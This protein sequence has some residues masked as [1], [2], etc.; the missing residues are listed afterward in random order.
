MRVC[1]DNNVG[2]Y[3]F[4]CPTCFGI[5]IKDADDRIVSLL[6]QSGVARENWTLPREMW[7]EHSNGPTITLDDV[8][9]FHEELEM[10]LDLDE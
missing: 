8:L 9:D 6:E 10:G 5:V 4:R 2:S 1:Q 7:E 3:R